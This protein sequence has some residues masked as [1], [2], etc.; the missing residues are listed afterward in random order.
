M[1]AASPLAETWAIGARVSTY[2]LAGVP[3]AAL[4]G[5]PS[6]KGRTVRDLFAHIH[7]VRLL[8][9]KAARP[10]LMEGLAKI[11][12]G[13]TADHAALAAALDASAAAI[14]RMVAEAAAGDGRVKG[15]KPHA[16][17]FVGYLL[18][19]EAHHR[20]QITQA[21]RIAGMPLDKKVS[22]GLWEW[23]VR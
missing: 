23:G 19:H 9:L 20:G 17:A 7:D 14:E 16:T 12:S 6:G 13:S 21:L 18:S 10:D 22:F 11:G 3:A 1:S 8:W 4:D 5:S 2:L 15:F